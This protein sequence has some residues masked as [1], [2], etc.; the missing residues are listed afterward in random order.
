[1]KEEKINPENLYH[2]LYRYYGPQGWWPLTMNSCHNYEKDSRGYHKKNHIVKHDSTDI[3]EIMTGAIL[4]QNTA[5]KNVEISINNLKNNGIVTAKKL[6]TGEEDIIKI[7]IKSSGYYNQKYKKLYIAFRW[8]LENDFLGDNSGGN[9]LPPKPS[10]DELLSIWG[11]GEETADSILLYAYNSPSF[12]IDAY[13]KRITERLIPDVKLKIY[14]DYK[15]YFEENIERNTELYNEY[16]ALIV[17]HSVELCRKKPVCGE[18]F[19]R[20]KCSYFTYNS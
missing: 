2:T 13:T 3:F 19:L 14:K 12:V 5:W 18:C 10:R 6:L 9:T 4:T 11:I 16:H 15:N 7:L 8:F 20:E 17:K 1:M